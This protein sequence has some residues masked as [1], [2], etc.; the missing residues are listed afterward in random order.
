MNARR[1]PRIF[2]FGKLDGLCRMEFLQ[3]VANFIE[4][5][6]NQQVVVEGVTQVTQTA[7]GTQITAPPVSSTNLGTGMNIKPRRE[8]FSF[9]KPTGIVFNWEFNE[10]V[11]WLTEQ[12]GVKISSNDFVTTTNQRTETNVD[13]KQN[14]ALI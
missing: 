4:D 2:L 10:Y 14:P 11:E 6:M 3:R 12:L 9:S 7:R 5:E 8:S 1:R 13:F